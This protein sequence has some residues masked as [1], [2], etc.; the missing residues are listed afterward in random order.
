[1][2][3]LIIIEDG[4]R[5]DGKKSLIKKLKIEIASTKILLIIYKFFR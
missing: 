3:N 4:N 5:Y 2:H 1:M